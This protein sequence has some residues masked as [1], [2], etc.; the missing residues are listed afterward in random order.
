MLEQRELEKT[1]PETRV[2]KN[3]KN[4]KEGMEEL[5]LDQFTTMQRKLKVERKD[6]GRF[7]RY[8]HYLMLGLE[9]RR[10]P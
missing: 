5:I 10:S 6:Y 8:N 1:K 9:N 3:Q 7:I 4:Y 2:I